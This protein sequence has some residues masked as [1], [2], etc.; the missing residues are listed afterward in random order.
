ML[1]ER[2]V[3][4]FVMQKFRFDMAAQFLVFINFALLSITASRDVHEFLAD[5]LHIYMSRYIV[6][7]I[8]AFLTF[9]LTWFVGYI[10]DTKMQ[11][12]QKITLIQGDRHP[13]LIDI[14]KTVNKIDER[15]DK[16]EERNEK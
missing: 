8:L 2:F 10:L 15:L 12:W 3:K 11:Y 9:F 6:I 14:L 1:K 4:F 5:V 7:C 13:Y 16:M